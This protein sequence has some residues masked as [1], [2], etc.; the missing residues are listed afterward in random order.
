MIK[1]IAS[2]LVISAVR[3]SVSIIPDTAILLSKIDEQEPFPYT[4]VSHINAL[5]AK[6][7]A[8]SY[9]QFRINA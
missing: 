5:L 7:L 2:P 1:N 8:T 6:L 4:A 9:L 3:L